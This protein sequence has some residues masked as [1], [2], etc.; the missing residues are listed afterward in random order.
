MPRMDG[1]ELASQIRKDDR[2]KHIPI[3]MITSRTGEKHRNLALDVG[4]EHYLG[5]PYNE[6]ELLKYIEE[7][8]K[9]K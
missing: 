7:V 2:L 5:K 3:I 6:A 1:Y 8:N 4:V 9:S